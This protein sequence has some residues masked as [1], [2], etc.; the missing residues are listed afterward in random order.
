MET[1][2]SHVYTV[3]LTHHDGGKAEYLAIVLQHLDKVLLGWL[4][5]ERKTRLLAILQRSKPIVGGQ[6][7]RGWENKLVRLK[8][9][10]FFVSPVKKESDQQTFRQLF[11]VQNI[12]TREPSYMWK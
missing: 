1:R 9:S 8:S 10:K 12:K 6:L 5:N 2:Y 3:I 11:S 7:L 4:R